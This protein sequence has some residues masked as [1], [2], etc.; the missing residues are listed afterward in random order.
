MA[1]NS[2][3][4][5]LL[6]T[7]HLSDVSAFPSPLSLSDHTTSIGTQSNKHEWPNKYLLQFRVWLI[8]RQSNSEITQKQGDPELFS[9][10]DW[11][12]IL[13]Q[14]QYSMIYMKNKKTK[15]RNI[16]K[17]KGI[18]IF[19]WIFSL[20]CTR[21][22]PSFKQLLLKPNKYWMNINNTWHVTFCN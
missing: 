7:R 4:V 8:E 10:L 9:T 11:K 22:K 1:L 18:I 19:F 5:C 6:L 17:I 13:I 15:N 12:L 2:L 21:V 20:N 3:L 14:L 16:S